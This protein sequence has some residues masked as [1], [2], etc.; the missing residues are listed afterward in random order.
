MAIETQIK[1]GDYDLISSGLVIAGGDKDLQIQIKAPDE[2]TLTFILK[3]DT[4]DSNKNELKR[5]AKAVNNTTLEIL[6]TNYNNILGSYSKEFW[7]I[8]TLLNRKLYL[9]YIIYGL[10]DTNLKKVEYSFYL[11]EEEQNG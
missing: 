6:F 1:S 4:E 2:N 9:T 11:G 7:Y 3:F 10:T 8:G 5:S